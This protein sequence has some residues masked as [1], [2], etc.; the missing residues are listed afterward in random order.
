MAVEL[1]PI[2]LNVP[3]ETESIL[4]AFAPGP[5]RRLIV[6]VGSIATLQRDTIVASAARCRLPAAYP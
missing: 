5:N 1:S 6:T 3:S 2:N 4:S